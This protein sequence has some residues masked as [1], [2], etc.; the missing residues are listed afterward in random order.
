MF[1]DVVLC[2]YRTEQP[3]KYENTPH[4]KEAENVCSFLRYH[5]S[6]WNF[7][8]ALYYKVIKASHTLIFHHHEP[9]MNKKALLIE[10]IYF[11][12]NVCK[13]WAEILFVSILESWEGKLISLHYERKIVVEDNLRFCLWV[14]TFDP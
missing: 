1:H 13:W 14:S 10:L 11:V 12:V 4:S 7:H 5:G 3:K 2:F 9:W 6:A 8:Q